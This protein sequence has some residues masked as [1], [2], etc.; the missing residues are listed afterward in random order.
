MSNVNSKVASSKKIISRFTCLFVA[1]LMVIIAMPVIIPSSATIVYAHMLNNSTMTRY[2]RNNPN[3]LLIRSN[4]QTTPYFRVREIMCGPG[5]G[6]SGC[7]RAT[8]PRFFYLDSRLVDVL[9]ATRSSLGVPLFVSGP[10]R[11]AQHAST[12][13]SGLGSFHHRGFAIDIHADGRVSLERIY[14]VA[15]ANGAVGGTTRHFTERNETYISRGGGFVHV[16]VSD[17]G[18]TTTITPPPQTHNTRV[19]NPHPIPTRNLQRGSTGNDVRWLQ[20]ELNRV[21]NAGLAVDGILGERTHAAILNFQRQQGIGA[22]GIV[23]PVTRD[24]I[25]RRA[26]GINQ[27]FPT[28]NLQLTNPMTSNNYVRWLQEALNTTNNARLN[29]DS[30]FGPLT[31]AAVM[32]YQRSRGLNPD[33]IVGPI[34]RTQLVRELARR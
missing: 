10:L 18:G 22:D 15:I 9:H 28:V 29:A 30:M 5:N 31:Q 21:S 7:N 11:C 13:R 16:A 14:D 33:G 34:T 12:F 4:G 3:Q 24:R 32:N 6:I 19:D 23:G 2:D 20:T 26:T 17:R 27:P 1:L 25:I 8:C